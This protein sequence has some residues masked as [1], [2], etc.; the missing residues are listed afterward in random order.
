M[1][2]SFYSIIKLSNNKLKKIKT[3]DE[4][5]QYF[6]NKLIELLSKDKNGDERACYIR[7]YVFSSD[8]PSEKFSEFICHLIE[9][10]KEIIDE[11]YNNLPKEVT[12][13]EENKSLKKKTLSNVGICFGG[14]G[15][16]NAAAIG[17]LLANTAGTITFL[18]NPL[19]I[20]ILAG[21]GITFLSLNIGSIIGKKNKKYRKRRN[22]QSY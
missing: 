17:A 11:I 14:I 4:K 20:G 1:Y 10:G 21:V 8:G 5:S 13:D 9:E 16:S 3:T 6:R 2:N 22:N 18:S 15:A 19:G 12:T 7:E